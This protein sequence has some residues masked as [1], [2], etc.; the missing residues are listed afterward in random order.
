MSFWKTLKATTIR[1]LRIIFKYKFE[2]FINI[3]W[4]ILDIIAFS[5]LGHIVETTSVDL[6]YSLRD[7]LLV[8]VFFWA[9]FGKSYD[10]TVNCIPEEASRGTLGFLLTNNVSFFT[11]LTARAAASSIISAIVAIC[12]IF[13][14]LALLNVLHL[15]LQWLLLA[16][17]IFLLCWLFMLGVSLLVSAVNVVLK[18]IGLLSALFL[19][20]LKI[21]SGYFFP[22]EALDDFVPGSSS[23]AMSLPTSAGLQMIRWV[24][25]VGAPPSEMLWT[26]LTSLLIGTTIVMTIAIITLKYMEKMSAK[27]GTLEFY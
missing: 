25:I 23:I 5:L 6:E 2:I 20:A 17:V 7:F 3:S 4:L 24:L 1:N 12:I 11:L 14:I 21:L 9:F 16:I 10:D 27:F 22:V 18:R 8:G 26:T 19:W 15:Q 13:P